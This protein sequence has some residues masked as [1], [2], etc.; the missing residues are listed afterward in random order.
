[1]AE[2]LNECCEQA[3]RE[4]IE[5]ITKG[6]RSYPLIKSIPCPTC[7]TIIPIRLYAPPSESNAA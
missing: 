6:L 7:R 5:R 4:Y 2:S 1:M 3:R